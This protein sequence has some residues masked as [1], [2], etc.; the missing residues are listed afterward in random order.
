[1]SEQTPH[2]SE[3]RTL[4]RRTFLKLLGAA[5]VTASQ[6]AA[7]APPPRISVI[8]DRQSPLTASEPVDWAVKKLQNALAEKGIPAGP[9]TSTDQNLS[10]I[11]RRR[12]TRWLR[13]RPLLRRLAAPGRS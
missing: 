11:C 12:C 13:L 5:A 1:M 4:E 3:R 9:E 2:L 6:D 7:A 8:V 10:H